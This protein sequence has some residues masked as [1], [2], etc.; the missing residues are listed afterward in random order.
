MINRQHDIGESG[1]AGE[2]MGGLHH[3]PEDVLRNN[4][5]P[6]GQIDVLGR[7]LECAL[8]VRQFDSAL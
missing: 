5:P 3:G 1:L 8:E 7:A 4:L 2:K 6:L